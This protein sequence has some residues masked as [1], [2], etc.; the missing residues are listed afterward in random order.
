MRDCA[1]SLV[2]AA[3]NGPALLRR[4]LESLARQT[5][6]DSTEILVVSNFPLEAEAAPE[7]GLAR[8]RWIP[9]PAGT[10]IPQLRTRGVRQARGAIVALLEDHGVLDAHWIA[11]IKAAHRL[12]HAAIGGALENDVRSRPLDWAV[13]FYDYGAYMPPNPAGEA[14]TLAGNNV[15]YKRAALAAVEAVYADGF[16]ETF[17]HEA[18]KRRG[19]T[20]YL[21]PGAIVHHCQSY[22]LGELLPRF[23]HQARA[24]AGKRAAG[25]APVRRLAMSAGSALLPVVLTV[26]VARRTLRKGRHQRQLWLSLPCLFLLMT[27]WA[28]GEWMGY[29]RGEGDSARHWK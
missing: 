19:E 14:E 9:L 10:A 12:P 13:Y 7:R 18:L 15:A 8:V 26:R 16:Y 1:L 5:D 11:E 21:A 27:S 23:Y 4:C 29:L 20:L 17:V 24:F 6:T 28:L 22:R 25:F 2:I 3:S